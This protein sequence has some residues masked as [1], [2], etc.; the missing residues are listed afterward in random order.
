M[1]GDVIG[2]YS[3]PDALGIGDQIVFGDM[4]QYSFVKNNTFNGQPLPGLAVLARDGSYRVIKSFGYQDFRG[5][6]G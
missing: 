5:K 3:F 2:D 1:T 6:L 4:M